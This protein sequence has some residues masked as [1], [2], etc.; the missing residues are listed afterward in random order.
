MSIHKVKINW[1]NE[2]EDFS[3]F[4][5]DRTHTWE[6]EGGKIMKASAAPEYMGAIEYIN[7]EEALAA[8]LSSCH[9]MS[10]LYVASKKKFVLESY[11]DDSEALLEKNANNKMAITKMYLKPKVT[12]RG[13]NQP[14][15]AA[16]DALHHLAHEECFIA[17]S[18]L[19][20]IIIEPVY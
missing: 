18:V 16:I 20:E 17:N 13:E 4:A 9:M 7:P 10:F 3:Y 11:E 8:A 2:K 6:F 1:K 14:D 15:K 5:Y 19:T 12:F